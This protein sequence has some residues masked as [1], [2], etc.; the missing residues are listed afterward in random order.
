MEAEQPITFARTHA[1]HVIDA[2]HGPSM[3]RRIEIRELPFVSRYLPVRM[4]ELLEQQEPQLLFRK[5]WI[6]YR[7]RRTMKR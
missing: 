1:I 4:L 3:H 6:D 5:L 7:K 2:P